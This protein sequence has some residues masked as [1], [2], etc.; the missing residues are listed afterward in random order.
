MLME[1]TTRIIEGKN[2]LLDILLEELNVKEVSLKDE[3]G[4]V[5]KTYD[6]AKTVE[7]K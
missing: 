6:G 3:K 4:E 7:Y 2:P 1:P 5:V